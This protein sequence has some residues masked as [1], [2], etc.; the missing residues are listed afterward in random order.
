MENK[1]S[2]SYVVEMRRQL[3]MYPEIGFDLPHTLKLVR[4]ELERMGISYT[5]QYGKSSI[6]ATINE[7][8]SHFTIGIRADMDAL[9]IVE[10]NDVPYKSRIEGQMHA[11]GHDAHTAVLL[12]T[13]R[14]LSLIKDQIDCRVKFVFQSCEEYAPSGAK[15]MADDGVMDDI[16]CIIALHCD[17]GYACGTAGFI[18]GSPNA[19]SRGFLLD[20]YGKSAHA[21]FQEKGIDAIA[22]AMK[23]YMA[24]ELV[25]AREVGAKV[26]CILNCGAVHGG[27]T[28][29]VVCDHASLYYT[30]RCW[31]EATDAHVIK[32]VKDIIAA[33]AMESG[34]K[35]TYT[36]KKFYPM[37][38]ND[39]KI[40]EKLKGAAEEVLGAENI[41]PHK[42]TMGGEDFSYFANKKP[43][44]LFRLGIRNEEKG[45]TAAVHED[46]FDIDEAALDLGSDI[47]VRFVQNNM[48]GI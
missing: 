14:K 23:A 39:D 13:A 31:D 38:H 11:C 42:R 48:H 47:F 46:N 9:P 40:F 3:H 44:C 22:M 34:G 7:E 24:I 30:L 29:N 32:R 8:K 37:L 1:T 2:N 43:A 20:F 15:L 26:P 17:A 16:D 33:V 12:D 21:A 19:S 25:A 41:K 27:V 18:Q 6:V 4:S 45:I 5:E 10:R 28:N 35:A 36:E